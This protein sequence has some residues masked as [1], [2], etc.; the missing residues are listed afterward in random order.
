MSVLPAPGSPA[1]RKTVSPLKLE[2]VAE[3]SQALRPLG[4]QDLHTNLFIDQLPNLYVAIVEQIV[5]SEVDAGSESG[6]EALTGA[7]LGSGNPGWDEAG[8]RGEE[9]GSSWEGEGGSHHG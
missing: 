7:G 6:L 2:R 3:V 1:Y 9:G 4:K 5:Q 8:Q